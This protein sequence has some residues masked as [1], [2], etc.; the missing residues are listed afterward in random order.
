MVCPGLHSIFGG[1][2]LNFCSEAGADDSLGFRVT[3][4]DPRFRV[5]R[6]AIS[7]GGLFGTVESF[8]RLPPITQPAIDE[9]ARH[10]VRDEFR[11]AMAMVL[12]GSRGLGEVT[13]KLLA[14]GGA[15]VLIGP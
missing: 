1:L 4:T 11:G 13:A 14:A 7:G 15:H 10:V 6:H 5:V 12:G 9:L 3:A 2:T 8:S